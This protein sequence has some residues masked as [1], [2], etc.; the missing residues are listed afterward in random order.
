MHYYESGNYI[1]SR[2]YENSY[3]Y[4]PMEQGRAKLVVSY[5]YRNGFGNIQKYLYNNEYT[6][7]TV[8]CIKKEETVCSG[9]S[10]NKWPFFSKG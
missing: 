8:N 6:E 2:D 3:V 10:S 9:S 4:T 1:G 5:Q 7:I